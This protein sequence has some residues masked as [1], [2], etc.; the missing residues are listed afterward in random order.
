[1]KTR[2]LVSIPIFVVLVAVIFIF[3][4]CDNNGGPESYFIYDGTTYPL[5][6]AAV[7]EIIPL[8]GLYN[9]SFGA[10]S[11]DIDLETM[12][13]IG[14]AIWIDLYSPTSTIAEGTYTTHHP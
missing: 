13:G 8:D 12:T 4:S 14:E 5:A 6:I 7:L 3:A 2:T 1:M 10:G 11:S 9:I